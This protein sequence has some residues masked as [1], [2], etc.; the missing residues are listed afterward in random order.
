MEKLFTRF[1]DVLLSIYI[2]NEYTGYVELEKLLAAVI[3][4][5]P[6][7]KEFIAAVSKHTD[8]EKK[9]YMMFKNYFIKNERM[10]FLVTE[11]Y[12]YINLFVKHIFNVR[13]EELDQNTVINNNKM[14]FKLCRL[15]MMT[16]FR[17]LKQVKT[18]LNSNIIK[19]NDALLRI[20]RVIE[21]DEPTHCYPYQ[22][23]LKRSNSHMPR[24]K[25]KLTDLWIHYSLMIIKVPVL[26]FNG[27]LKR[28]NE[29]Y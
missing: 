28:M 9:H 26:L 5:Y 24:L 4:K 22:Y 3:K 14:F 23:W 6:D 15:I 27:K 21:K 10:P 1:Y 18:L 20:F 8:D 16:E 7:E 17:G 12:G 25:E 29:F 19:K 11:K 13:V 2:Y